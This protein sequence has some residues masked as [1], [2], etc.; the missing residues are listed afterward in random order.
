MADRV[1][2]ARDV[3]AIVLPC[4]AKGQYRGEVYEFREPVLAEDGLSFPGYF[5]WV[6]RWIVDFLGG[7]NIVNFAG[8]MR[9]TV[10]SR[11]TSV[12]GD[13]LSSDEADEAVKEEASEDGRQQAHDNA[14]VKLPSAEKHVT[15]SSM[16]KRIAGV[17]RKQSTK[18]EKEPDPDVKAEV[19]EECEA[20]EDVVME[21][22]EGEEQ[23]EASDFSV[24]TIACLC[25]MS[26]MMAKGPRADARWTLSK[27]EV[28]ERSKAW[29][30][31]VQDMFWQHVDIDGLRVVQG[32]LSLSSV[33]TVFGKKAKKCLGAKGE[34]DVPVVDAL[35]ALQA[36]AARRSLG[37]DRRRLAEKIFSRLVTSL[38]KAIDG[39]RGKP[40]WTDVRVES[41][42]QLRTGVARYCKGPLNLP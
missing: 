2:G 12:L 4:G 22:A 37:K 38:A 16:M 41:L 36:D 26:Q 27:S 25:W 40:I 23:L 39:S 35:A 34:E 19:K 24:S 3:R 14:D 15:A 6:V 33:E 11:T 7:N 5:F 29:L 20:D 18:P 17:K 31:G 32:L 10:V 30:V 1:V 28:Q 9:D 21:T 42:D 13:G 8:K